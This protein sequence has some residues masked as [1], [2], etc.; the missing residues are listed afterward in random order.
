MRETR[1]K[2]IEGDV[3]KVGKRKAKS[4]SWAHEFTIGRSK[5][6]LFSDDEF[7][8]FRAGDKLRFTY[9]VRKLRSGSRSRYFAIQADTIEILDAE[10]GSS[11]EGGYVYILS[12]KSMPGSLKI[13]HTSKSPSDRATELSHATGVPTPFIVEGAVYIRGNSELVERAVHAEL[14]THRKGKEFFSVSVDRARKTI[15]QKYREIYPK[16]STDQAAAIEQRDAEFEAERNQALARMR[17]EQQRRDYENSAEFKWKTKGY[18]FVVH[19]DF[20][21]IPEKAELDDRGSIVRVADDR[22][23]LKRL[24]VLEDMPNWMQAQIIGRRNYWQTGAMPWRVILT[25]F[26]NGERCHWS[27]GEAPSGDMPT[28]DRALSFVTAFMSKLGVDNHR[29]SI[30]IATDLIVDPLV[31]DDDVV[32]EK[33]GSY[34]I[35]RESLDGIQLLGDPGVDADLGATGRQADE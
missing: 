19:R 32:V 29:I 21:C 3:L 31:L 14:S 27:T 18:L 7:C 17:E 20:E 11:D 16:E 22:S 33:H 4:G 8:P 9:D 23:F 15:E 28:L 26:R 6:S 13:G 30:E 12:N 34:F 5:Y 1:T 35:R 25:G 10:P 2:T 24:F